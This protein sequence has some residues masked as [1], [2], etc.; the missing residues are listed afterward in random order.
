MNA[1]E[2]L[3]GHVVELIRSGLVFEFATVSKAGV[4]IDTPLLYFPAEDL[5]TIDCA[6]GLAYPSKAERARRNPRVGLLI[7]G[8]APG[9]PIVSIAGLAQVEDT[10]IQ[11]NS[12][13]YIAETATGGT[14]T[15]PWSKA[16]E[17]VW[18]WSRIIMRVQPKRVLWWES[19]AAMDGPPQV[20]EAPAETLQAPASPPPPGELSK[21]PEWSVAEWRDL[22]DQALAGGK[23]A[24]LTLLD[25]EG[26][27]LPFRISEVR[28][29]AQGF[30]M[31]A[32]PAASRPT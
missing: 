17:A 16:R 23:P 30:T 3:P 6:T 24:H 26:F 9:E 2:G 11:A 32:S 29:T 14:L 10:D 28:K 25:A 27:P 19:P 12:L 22:A 5:S 8:L 13:R 21:A 18:Y 31:R 1:L 20:W 7:E 15:V 4:P